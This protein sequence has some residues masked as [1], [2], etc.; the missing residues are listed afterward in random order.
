MHLGL[1]IRKSEC[2]NA[3]RIKYKK[4]ECPYAFRI[5]YKK[6]WVPLMHLRFKYILKNVSALMHLA[7]NII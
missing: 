6:K 1:N 4:S 2:H 5:K 7:L 3:F